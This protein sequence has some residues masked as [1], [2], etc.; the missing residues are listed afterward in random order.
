MQKIAMNLQETP[1]LNYDT[2]FC[3]SCMCVRFEEYVQ[4]K[5]SYAG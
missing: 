1:I 4:Y 3:L 5:Y 2:W